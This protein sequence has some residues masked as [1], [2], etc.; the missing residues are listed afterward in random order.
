MRRVGIYYAYW[1]REWDVDFMPMVEKAARLGFE[2]LELNGGTIAAMPSEGRKR[3][4]EAA[5]ERGLALSYGI[6]LPRDRDPSSLDESTR[7][8]GVAFMRGMIGAVAEMGGGMIGGTV[9]SYWPATPPRD[10]EEKRAI[11]AS[12]LRSMRELGPAAGGAGVV[13]NV[14]VINRFEQFLLNTCEEALAFVEEVGHPAVGMLL[15]TFHMNIEEDS[16]GGAIRRAGKRLR[17]FHIGET[18]RKLPGTGRMPWGEIR[19]AL[20][21]IGY[22]GPLV[23]EPF[24]VP[25]GGVG[26][27]IG[28]WR[29]LV[30]GA[31]LDALAA[32]SAEFVKKA[33][34]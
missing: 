33:L 24:V 8:A 6:G 5:E 4:R 28:L 32:R 26:R 22:D 7:R 25:G 3:I 9:H 34:R 27:D 29:E 2:Q 15:D 30:P 11:R 10:L 23:M 31:D 18:N 16:I 20:D 19:S 1:A 12:A 17:S 13:L 14:E 21:D